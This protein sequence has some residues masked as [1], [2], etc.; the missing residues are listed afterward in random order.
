M[1]PKRVAR[2]GAVFGFFSMPVAAY[3]IYDRSNP[4]PSPLDQCD[5][6]LMARYYIRKALWT[7]NISDKAYNLDW[8]MQKVLAA[9]YG[10]AS[11]QST[12]LVMYLSQLYLDERPLKLENLTASY[13][14]LTHKPHVGEGVKEERARLE[15][16]FQVAATLCSLLAKS[17]PEGAAE[18]AKRALATMDK[19]PP[20]LSKNWKN[21]PLRDT[22]SAYLA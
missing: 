4:F 6:P 7:E 19:A 22:L 13:A 16:S 17:N 14:A 15:L 1:L 5:Y 9:G 10:P 3:G 21:H 20:F 8:A 18:F 2:L 11:P 12:A